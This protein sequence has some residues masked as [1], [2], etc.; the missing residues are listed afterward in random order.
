MHTLLRFSQYLDLLFKLFSGT[1]TK[2]NG[3]NIKTIRILNLNFDTRYERRLLLT[4]SV[5]NGVCA[6]LVT[7]VITVDTFPQLCSA[8]YLPLARCSPAT[9]GGGTTSSTPT[10]TT[11]HGAT[12]PPW[13][14][15]SPSLRQPRPSPRWCGVQM[16]NEGRGFA[17]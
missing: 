13:P 8:L 5:L 2:G 11:S 3:I 14:P 6:I 9:A 1:Y 12:P 15:P 7:V 17:T 4:A 10:I 16:S